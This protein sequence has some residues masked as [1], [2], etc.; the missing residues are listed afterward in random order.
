MFVSHSL[1]SSFRFPR[2]TSWA[3]LAAGMALVGCLQDADEAQE[4]PK[5]VA[6]AH[7]A[8]F[9]TSDFTSGLLL[10][11]DLDSLKRGTDSLEIFQDSRVITHG[12]EVFVLEAI[13]A[14][15][16]LKYDP[17]GQKV[18][19]QKKLRTALNPRDMDWINDSVAIIVGENSPWLYKCNTQTGELFD[20]L[21][22]SEFI[23]RPDSGQGV[24]AATPHAF[25][26]KVL[27]DSALVG[28]QRRNGDWQKSGG[29]AQIAVL[30]LKTFSIQSVLTATAPNAQSLWVDSKFIY[31]STQGKNGVTDDG[32]IFKWRRGE[33]ELSTLV[34]GP[35]LNGDVSSV[36]CDAEGNCLVAISP[37]WGETAVFPLD[38]ATG[39]LSGALPGLKDAW[40]GLLYDSRAKRWL[41]GERSSENSGILVF[42]ST[43]KLQEPAFPM[44]L[45]PYS[46]AAAE[47]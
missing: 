29:M 25:S 32:G 38:L 37:K 26:V 15:N 39:E 22:L 18:V 45:P 14:D 13:G 46:A 10:S 16:L 19:Y 1:S 2:M 21:N 20:S 31:M 12:K 43:F 23:F 5:V 34:D 47:F 33:G 27:G 41:V 28:L 44:S 6:K 40:G 17:V 30:N 3:L 11:I 7:R 9:T 24:A 42:D 36:A 4:P 8:F 35:K